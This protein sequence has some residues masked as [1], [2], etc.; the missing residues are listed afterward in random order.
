[1]LKG[2]P[3]IITPELLKVLDEMGHGDVL[4]I[5]DS[6]FPA[7]SIAK[8][9]NHI[10]IRMDGHNIIEVLDSILSLYPIDT[11]VDKPVEVMQEV[12]KDK[13]KGK[14]IHDDFVKTI[15]KHDKR[16]AALVEYVERFSFYEK[17]KDAYAVI[18]T[19]ETEP[20][21]CILIKKGTV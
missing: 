17:A 21:A 14:K 4:A 10:N 13:G 6:N 2:I 3:A 7:T 1:M 5:G 12:E 8:S 18:S 19:T 9:K 16:G 15:E 11:F 20:Y